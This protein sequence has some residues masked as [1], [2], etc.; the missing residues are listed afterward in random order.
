MYF[1]AK[2]VKGQRSR[3]LKIS[4]AGLI[5]LFASIPFYASVSLR[6][7]TGIGVVIGFIVFIA[8][9]IMGRG[10]TAIY[11]ID[12]E[13]LTFRDAWIQIGPVIYPLPE[14]SGLFFYYDSFNGQSENGYFPEKSRKISKWG[15]YNRVSFL[16]RGMKISTTFYLTSYDHAESFF[17]CLQE[18]RDMGVNYIYESNKG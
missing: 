14:I 4:Y 10:N 7:V 12:G 16:Y 6:D 8:G 2:L 11:K 17:A 15:I 5:I 1:E 9:I 18:W 3:A 13:L